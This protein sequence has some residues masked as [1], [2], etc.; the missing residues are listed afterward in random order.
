MLVLGNFGGIFLIRKGFFMRFLGIGKE[1]PH[2]CFSSCFKL[3]LSKPLEYKGIHPPSSLL[4]YH[5]ISYFA[6]VSR[7]RK[8][9]YTLLDLPC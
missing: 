7:R 4:G 5:L 8:K 6:K 1:F 3:N 2:L 9:A